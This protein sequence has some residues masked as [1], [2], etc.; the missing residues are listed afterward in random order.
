MSA[1]GC[2]LAAV[3]QRRD[4]AWSNVVFIR[5]DNHNMS[6]PAADPQP[7]TSIRAIPP[8]AWAL[9]AASATMVAL[10]AHHPVMGHATSYAEKMAAL[11]RLGTS[12]ALVHGA[13]FGVVAVL[14]YGVTTLALALDARR[15][16]VAFGLICHALGCGAVGGAMLL[17]GFITAPLAQAALDHGWPADAT[18]ASFALVSIGIQM[19]TKAGLVGMG[20]GMCC[21][22]W[23]NARAT[24]LLA[25]L[26]L[27]AGLGTAFAAASGLRMHTHSLVLLTSLQALW[28]AGAALTLWRMRG[29]A[30]AVS[31]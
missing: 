22:S 3:R 5:K 29:T 16:A 26:A 7:T 21:L 10:L 20:A 25:A 11:A 27:P 1:S 13:L 15:P 17:D 19:L 18:A 23:S 31:R 8:A 12:A 14:L 24:R 6:H 4:R 30:P 9:V 28:Y 2:R